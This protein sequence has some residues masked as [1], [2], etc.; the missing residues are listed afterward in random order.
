VQNEGELAGANAVVGLLYSA[1]DQ[2]TIEGLKLS[3]SDYVTL[4]SVAIDLALGN[5]PNEEKGGE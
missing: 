2:K 5:D 1:K 3:I 4:A